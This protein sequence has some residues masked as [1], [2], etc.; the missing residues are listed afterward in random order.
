MKYFAETNSIEPH[1]RDF[2]R[3]EANSDQ[4]ALFVAREAA[5]EN[6]QA[7][8]GDYKAKEYGTVY[9]CD[10]QDYQESLHDIYFEEVDSE[11]FDV[12]V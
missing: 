4:E 11:E 1:T 12:L 3:F 7:F 2:I 9:W 8:T 6:Y 10:V 5:K